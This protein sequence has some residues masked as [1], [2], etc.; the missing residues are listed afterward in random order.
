MEKSIIRVIH[1]EEG[2][3][4]GDAHK[5]KEERRKKRKKIFQFLLTPGF[6]SKRQF[7]GMFLVLLDRKSDEQC[8]LLALG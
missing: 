3:R 1:L 5:K 4:S 7:P 6:T 8:L 2:V